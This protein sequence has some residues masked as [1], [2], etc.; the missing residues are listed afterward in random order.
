GDS[1]RD[2]GVDGS[3]RA[4]DAARARACREDMPCEGSQRTM[5][6]GGRCGAPVQMDRRDER[7][8]TCGPKAAAA[9]RPTFTVAGLSGGGGGGGGTARPCPPAARA[10]PAVTPLAPPPRA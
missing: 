4:G 5:A 1:H 2:A 8:L 9:P 7:A 6:V 10:R 3:A